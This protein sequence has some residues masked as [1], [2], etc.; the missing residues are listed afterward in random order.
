MNF[1]AYYKMRLQGLHFQN[2]KKLTSLV[3]STGND[4]CNVCTNFSF[5]VCSKFRKLLKHISLNQLVGWLK[6]YWV[7]CMNEVVYM[8]D[9]WIGDPKHIEGEEDTFSTQWYLPQV[10]RKLIWEHTRQWSRVWM[11]CSY[12]WECPQGVEELHDTIK[13]NALAIWH[14]SKDAL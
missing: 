11:S 3:L 14:S 7:D 10:R 1:Q 13:Y 2:T 9:V 5:F 6:M 4:K 12:S 8:S